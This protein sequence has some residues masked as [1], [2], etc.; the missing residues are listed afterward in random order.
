MKRVLTNAMRHEG[1]ATAVEFA[2]I[3]ALVAVAIV[4]GAMSLGNSL[5]D[6]FQNTAA[7]VADAEQ[8]WQTD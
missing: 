6:T 3:G 2:L 4:V 5:A 7:D 8:M 1:G